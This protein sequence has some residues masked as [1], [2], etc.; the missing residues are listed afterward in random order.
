MFHPKQNKLYK[1][2]TGTKKESDCIKPTPLDQ[3]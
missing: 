2:G 3:K 1:I